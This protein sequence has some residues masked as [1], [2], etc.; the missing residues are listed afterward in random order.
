MSIRPVRLNLA[1]TINVVHDECDHEGT[2]AITDIKFVRK[3]DGS[4][5]YRFI[6]LAC[7]VE[8]CGAVSV[9]PVS[10]GADPRRVQRLFVRKLLQSQEHTS[11]T[12]LEAF[13]AARAMAEKMDGPA[14]WKFRSLLD[15]D[16]DD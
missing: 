6:E 10:G 7:P 1:A 2:V 13:Q 9:H 4:P 5:D 14:R 8:G 15:L 3:P 11:T 16:R 12:L